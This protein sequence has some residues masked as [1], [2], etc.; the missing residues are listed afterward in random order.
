MIHGKSIQAAS[1]RMLALLA[2]IW[3]A[4]PLAAG[5][6]VWT[7]SSF[8]DF[9]DGSFSDGGVNTYVTV[10][11]EVVL[12]KLLDLNHDG[13]VDIVIPNDHDPHERA[14]LFIYWGGDEGYSPRRHSRLPT[15]G[16]HDGAV[17][18]L[19][20]D[21]NPEL[22]VANNFNGT[23]TVLD[24][25]IYRGAK[26]GPK[27]SGRT[28]L[29]TRG[30]RAV[31]V[32]DLNRDGHPDIVFANSGLDYHVTVDPH[33]ESFVYWGS[34]DGYSAER[35]QVLRTVNS[36]DVKVADLDRDGHLDLVFA[37][38]GNTDAEGGALLYW[39]T[40]EGDYT[41]REAVHL[42]GDRSSAVEVADLN[43]DG[44]PEVVLANA[45]RLKTREMGMYNIVDTV[46][47]PSFIYWGS[48][49][50]YS[51][52]SKTLLPTVGASDVASGDLNRDGHVDLVFANKSG[53]ASFIYWGSPD[54]YRSHRRTSIPTKAPTRCLVEDLDGDGYPEL[55]F[56]QHGG[57]PHGKPPAYV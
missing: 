38:E 55:V 41:G 32:E 57:Q 21:G 54:G 30:A 45:Y 28:G 36:R 34:P 15:N 44:F 29:P 7:S 24:S 17:A 6:K 49:K 12:I 14:D 1:V 13:R 46:S 10:Q 3:G 47:V 37:N 5:E 11:G 16:G 26:G 31:A 20:G 33:N 51:V 27:A 19:D 39:G 25:F 40:S 22:I 35:R 53:L 23:R 8:L 52:E 48:A 56:S 9:A 2:L 43:G 42:P 4:S 50:G 18:D